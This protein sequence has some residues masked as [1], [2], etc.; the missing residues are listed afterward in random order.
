M[1]TPKAGVEDDDNSADTVH[2]LPCRIRVEGGT[3]VS[4][5]GLFTFSAGCRDDGR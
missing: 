1:T 2:A 4:S 3:K 5:V